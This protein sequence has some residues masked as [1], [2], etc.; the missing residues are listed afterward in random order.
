MA[1]RCGSNGSNGGVALPVAAM[2]NI[3]FSSVGLS[4]RNDVIGVS[5]SWSPE[6][7]LCP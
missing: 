2:A 4:A 1:G 3:T 5:G 7:Y 6:P